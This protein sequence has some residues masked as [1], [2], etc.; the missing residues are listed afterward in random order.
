MRI[1]LLFFFFFFFFFFFYYF[2]V[3]IRPGSRFT[4]NVKT[5][6]FWIIIIIIINIWK[7]RLLQLW[8]AHYELTLQW[9]V[10]YTYEQNQA[11][12]TGN[13]SYIEKKREISLTWI[14]IYPFAGHMQQG[15]KERKKRSHPAS[16]YSRVLNIRK[17]RKKERK[18]K[19]KRKRKKERKDAR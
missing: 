9:L 14:C 16:A 2:S 13:I 18:R 3:K 12:L 6:C 19:K 8:L 4:W 5:Y 17:K 11:K 1:S 15:K 10:I 7:R